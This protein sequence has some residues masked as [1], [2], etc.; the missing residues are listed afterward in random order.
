MVQGVNMNIGP[1]MM[2]RKPKNAADVHLDLDDVYVP[3]VPFPERVWP[4][5]RMSSHQVTDGDTTSKV[6]PRELILKIS[7]PHTATPE[8][9]KDEGPVEQNLISLMKAM[10]KQHAWTGGL[11]TVV[12]P[13]NIETE[14]TT[15]T[16]WAV[17]VVAHMQNQ[18]QAAGVVGGMG[19]HHPYNTFGAPPH[20]YGH[21]PMMA[22]YGGGGGGGGGMD[23]Y[24]AYMGI[25]NP[26]LYPTNPSGGMYGQMMYNHQFPQHYPLMAPH[27]QRSG[28]GAGMD[29]SMDGIRSGP[30][31][32]DR[33]SA[34]YGDSDP[35]SP[36]YSVPPQRDTDSDIFRFPG[37]ETVHES[38][39]AEILH[40]L[41]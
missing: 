28:A 33:T 37:P 25:A 21:D 40:S 11:V 8:K 7:K 1:Y 39:R 3:H 27:S 5:I 17:P 18:M 6:G 26:L 15:T 36:S 2:Y 31:K 35:S 12:T 13:K 9:P 32:R 41:L 4:L 24:A 22:M 38:T 34:G 10:D 30:L 20:G 29:T 23:P 14:V 16:T 19:G